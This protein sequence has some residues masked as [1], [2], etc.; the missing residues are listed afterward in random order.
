MRCQHLLPRAGVDLSVVAKVVMLTTMAGFRD[1]V[2]STVERIIE[3]KTDKVRKAVAELKARQK[4]AGSSEVF[5]WVIPEKLACG[6]RPLRHHPLYGGSGQNLSPE[7]APEVKK[8][9]QLVHYGGIR[10]IVSLM[11]ARDLKYYERLDLGAPNLID[12]YR[13][14][15]FEVAHIPWDDPHHSKTTDDQIRKKLMVIRCDALAAY[16]RLPKPVMVQCSAGIDRTAPV[17]AYIW[18]QRGSWR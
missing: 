7:A 3:D 15:G 10:S 14:I 18:A 1:L 2:N 16:D 8:W 12:F 4:N 17:A 5:C 6:Q 11:H 13:S 9:A